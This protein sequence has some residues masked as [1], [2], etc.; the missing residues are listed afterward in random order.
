MY[1]SSN[2]WVPTWL[3]LSSSQL[4]LASTLVD[5]LSYGS[6]DRHL[7]PALSS[8]NS[9]YRILL[10]NGCVQNAVD[11]AT[12]ANYGT[13]PC[14]YFYPYNFCYK[15]PSN[16]DINY[17]VFY[18]GI[19]GTGL[20]PA[21]RQYVLLARNLIKDRAAALASGVPLPRID[22][23]APPFSFVD[24]L[25]RLYLPAGL[26]A[27]SQ[28]RVD[29]DTKYLTN[30][31]DLNLLATLLCILTLLL[32]YICTYRPLFAKLDKDI[33]DTRGL[34]LLLPEEAA[35]LVPAVLNAGK[36]LLVSRD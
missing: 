9:A 7:R 10:E 25:G 18:Y 30:F 19:V 16:V 29:E 14:N 27:L 31:G 6:V 1:N 15:P 22:L 26:E 21:L 24:Q 35:R 5:A 23:T 8:S 20:L 3:N 34:L 12:C 13:R 32:F 17:P 2:T 4:E 28:G 11:A 36:K 33:K